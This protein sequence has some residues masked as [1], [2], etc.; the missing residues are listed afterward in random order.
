LRNK[1]ARILIVDDS[2]QDLRIHAGTLRNQGY[3]VV[4][5]CS[6]EEALLL[7]EAGIP[8]LFLIETNL[9]GM[10]GYTLCERIKEDSRLLNTPVIFVTDSRS[11]EDIDHGYSAGAVDYIVKPCHLSEFLARV[12]THINL[13]ELLREVERLRELA[14]DANPLTHLPGNNTIVSTIQE[15]IEGNMDVAIVYCD[16]D[17]F[18]A[19]NDAYGFNEG[20]EVLLFT[21]ETLQTVLRLTC[22]EEY[23]LGHIGGDDFVMMV[24]ADKMEKVGNEVARRFDKG[25]PAFYNE[26]DQERGF[27]I[28]LDRQGNATEFPIVSI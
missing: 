8:D 15:A 14:I 25:A 1:K 21:A 6:A 3:D 11:P 10:D 7:V 26:E 9:S 5:A 4:T 17:N 13:Y 27:I 18:K 19:Y 2:Q 28:S 24:P 16:L 23:F 12:R 20:D 22:G